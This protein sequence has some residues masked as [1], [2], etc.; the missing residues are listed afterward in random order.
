MYFI[1]GHAQQRLRE[2]LRAGQHDAERL[3]AAQNEHDRA[4]ADGGVD[5]S[6]RQILPIEGLID[7]TAADQAVHGCNRAAFGQGKNAA[8]DDDRY[9]QRPISFIVTRRAFYD[10]FR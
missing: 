5:Q 4:R 2:N 7:I 8:Q 3:H 10:I 6:L 9:H 1:D